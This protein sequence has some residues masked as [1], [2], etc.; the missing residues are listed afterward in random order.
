MSGLDTNV[1]TRWLVDDDAAQTDCVR[2]LFESARNAQSMLFIPT[3]V[4]LE[5]EW[6]LRS[7]YRYDKSAVMQAFNALLETQELEFQGEAAL[8]RALHRY[9]QSAAEFADCLHAGQCGAAERLPFLTF[10]EKA[11]RLPDVKLLKA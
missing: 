5:L 6:V 11:A 3:T 1:L 10:D 7:R 4:M 2:Q 8:E 9:R